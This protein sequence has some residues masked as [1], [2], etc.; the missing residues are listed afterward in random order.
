MNLEVVRGEHLA[1]PVLELLPLELQ[2]ESVTWQVRCTRE[3]SREAALKYFWTLVYQY[4]SS[5]AP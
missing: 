2:K 5:L 4:P 1:Y 3:Q